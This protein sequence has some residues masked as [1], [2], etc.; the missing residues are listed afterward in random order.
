MVRLAFT[1]GGW[2]AVGNVTVAEFAGVLH[3]LRN[4]KA[5]SK[6]ACAANF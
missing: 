2:V 4:N 5:P 6:V 3:A 1:V